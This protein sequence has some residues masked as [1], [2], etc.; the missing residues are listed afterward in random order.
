M[1]LLIWV[2]WAGVGSIALSGSN[3]ITLVNLLFIQNILFITLL[4]FT[5]NSAYKFL[6]SLSS[7]YMI[8][9]PECNNLNNS[10]DA[11]V[12]NHDFKQGHGYF[13]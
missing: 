2:K 10:A 3:Q 12:C 13:F 11:A 6:C 4:S 1:K 7:D 5:S 9:E 8:V